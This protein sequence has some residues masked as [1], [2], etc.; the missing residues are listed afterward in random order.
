MVC[1]RSEGPGGHTIACS[2]KEEEKP[3]CLKPLIRKTRNYRG[4][5][6]GNSR[7]DNWPFCKE[8]VTHMLS[9]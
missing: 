3:F 8:I 9:A 5:R 1:F 2:I 7:I 4:E 6:E